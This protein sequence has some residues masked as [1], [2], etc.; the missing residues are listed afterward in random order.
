VRAQLLTPPDVEPIS[1]ADAKTH[2]RADP[3]DAEDTLIQLLITA[4]RQWVE[5]YCARALIAQAWRLTLPAF[6]S[7]RDGSAIPLARPPIVSV[8]SVKYQDETGAEDTLDAAD[9]VLQKAGLPVAIAPAVDTVWPSTEDLGPFGDA[10]TIDYT[11][12]YGEAAAEVPAPIR[13]AILLVLGDLYANREA[14]IVG[15]ITS[16]NPT[17]KALLAPFRVLEAV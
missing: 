12:G 2:L 14:Q 7:G 9:Y 10:V 11:A 1:L 17:V 6:P 16:E 5:E 3:G 13:A 8:E 15:T 4:A